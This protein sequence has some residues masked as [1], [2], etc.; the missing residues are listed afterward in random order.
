MKQISKSNNTDFEYIFGDFD[1][2]LFVIE[3][4]VTGLFSYSTAQLIKKILPCSN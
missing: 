3:C 2:N 1:A 4:R